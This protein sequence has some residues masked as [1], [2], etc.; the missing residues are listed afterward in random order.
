MWLLKN[1]FGVI[2]I[3]WSKE[4]CQNEKNKI[5]A[6]YALISMIN[7]MESQKLDE[8]VNLLVK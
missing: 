2:L 1:F 4:N 3:F 7:G 8:I 6:I 5:Y